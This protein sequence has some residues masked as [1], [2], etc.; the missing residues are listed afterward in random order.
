MQEIYTI[1]KNHKPEINRCKK[2]EK[3]VKVEKKSSTLTLE[4]PKKY[5]KGKKVNM[6]KQ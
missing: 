5:L 1:I 6:S 4:R 3:E 2:E